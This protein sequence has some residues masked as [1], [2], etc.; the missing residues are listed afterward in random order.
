ML[1][2]AAALSMAAVQ[3]P[4]L[5]RM[6]PITREPQITYLDRA[7]AV[8][9]VRG[10]RYAP[11][12]DIAKLPA[13]VPAA[14]VAIEDRRFYEH[15]GFDARGIARAVVAGIGAGRPTQGA[16]T[17]TQQLA[18]NLFLTQERTLE[19]KATELVYA[20]ELERTYTKKQILGLYLSRVYF[21]SGAYGLEA[22]SQ[23]YF[24]KAAAR[25]SLK[26]AAMLAGV[27]KSPSG[28]NPVEQ[29][30]RCLE[31]ARLVLNAMV[32][33]GAI[34]PAQRDKAAAQKPRVWKTAP[35][36]PA[37]Y[38]LDWVDGEVRRMVPKPTRDLMVETT[39]DQAMEAAAGTAVRA[40]V[41]AWRG[42][43]ADQAAIVAI[44]GQ[45]RVRALVGGTNHA[46]APYNRAVSARRQAGSAWK[47]IVYL[48]ALERGLTPD[49]PVVDEP[50]TIAGWT[51]S[52]YEVGAYLGPITLETALAKSVN[53]VAARL[54]DEV[55][56]PAIAQT[57][58]RIGIAS[59][60][61][62]DPAMALGTTLVSPLEL[63]QAYAAFSNGGNRVQPYG[64]ER[65]RSGGQVIFQKRPPAPAP[66]V[67]NPALSDLNRMLRT[68]MTSGT[69]ARAAIPG[70]D[71]A[72]K[73][74]T[75]SDYKDAWFCGY[76]GGLASCAWMGRDDGRPMARISGSTAPAQMWR[77]FMSTALKR[78]PAQP[79]P[80]G[81]PPVAPP[82][83][84]AEEAVLPAVS[85][86]PITEDMPPL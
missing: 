1:S 19:R 42:Q 53:T 54:A 41:E 67:A 20:V 83:Q 33:T 77:S 48:T 74:G 50:V 57:A 5:P 26:E 32:E 4:D 9:G 76:T 44:D 66:A 39:L 40:G 68:V 52:N 6:P 72:G 86:P 58:R 24:N 62:T 71:L 10:G 61:N 85:P 28:Y 11:P 55:G 75:T 46:T 45:G 13:H 8:I 80:A 60:V 3:A 17:I 49:S 81:P 18:R 38:F 79:I 29:P 51:P 43:G 65:I 73:T 34:T 37:Q 23:R 82:A 16:S 21:G 70:H 78:I 84:P 69:G 36:G 31:R 35:N 59:T 47:P 15:D 7:G 30:E 63:T 64:I 25:L 27:L 12:V 2:L 56:R 22:A 14:F